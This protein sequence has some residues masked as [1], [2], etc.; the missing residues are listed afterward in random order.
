VVSFEA[1]ARQGALLAVVPD[2]VAHGRAAAR[3]AKVIADGTPPTKAPTPET[4]ALFILNQ[5]TARRLSIDIPD[6]FASK[7]A[8]VI[9]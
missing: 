3:L 9:K 4:G 5:R 1:H 7:A 6:D 8:S 2:P